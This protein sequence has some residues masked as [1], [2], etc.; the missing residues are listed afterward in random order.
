MVKN[1]KIGDFGNY[2]FSQKN[3]NFEWKTTLKSNKS[4]PVAFF[5]AFRSFYGGCTRFSYFL[6]DF[7]RFF[8]A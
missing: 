7:G 8:E 6:V 1:S 2:D 3:K 4:F 5:K